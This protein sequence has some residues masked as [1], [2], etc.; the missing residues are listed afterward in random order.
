MSTAEALFQLYK[1]FSLKT[2]KEIYNLIFEKEK[3]STISL[4]KRESLKADKKSKKGNQ[5]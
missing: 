2:Q 3:T 1:S 4:S 5:E